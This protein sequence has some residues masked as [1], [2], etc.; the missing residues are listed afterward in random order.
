MR[1]DIRDKTDGPVTHI[2]PPYCNEALDDEVSGLNTGETGIGDV[3]MK[4]Q[5]G[6][7][8]MITE[9]HARD[10]NGNI[11]KGYHGM[12]IYKER[13]FNTNVEEEP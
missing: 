11:S 1:K 12:L 9:M 2:D 8:L 10:F 3:V 7:T 13:D 4:G 5:T 6:A